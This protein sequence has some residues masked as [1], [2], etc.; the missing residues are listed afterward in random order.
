MLPCGWVP[1]LD[2][3]ILVGR[4]FADENLRAGTIVLAGIVGGHADEFLSGAVI[5]L[6]NHVRLAAVDAQPLRLVVG[7]GGN[8]FEVGEARLDGIMEL[9][10]AR[11][12][13]V[14]TIEP[15]LVADFD[16]GELERPRVAFLR[17]ARAPRRARITG[18]I[19]NLLQRF[20]H[21]RFEIGARIDVHA[22]QRIAGVNGQ[23]R[24]GLHVLAPFKKLQKAHSIRRAVTPRTGMT[25][26]FFDQDQGSSS[27]QSES[28]PCCL[29]GSCRPEN[30]RTWVPSPP[31][32]ASNL[33]GGRSGGR[34]KSAEKAKPDR[35]TQF[36]VG[37]G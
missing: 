30:A 28:R 10:E 17:A 12:V 37:R 36:R 4:P 13:A 32:S 8:G 26:A 20:L 15:V 5:M 1:R 2:L 11:V 27:S 31:A 23:H 9:R 3:P 7:N 6:V 34:S 29:R 18:D 14:R 19:L 33:S 16:I 21:V 24:F 22:A 35:A 25:V